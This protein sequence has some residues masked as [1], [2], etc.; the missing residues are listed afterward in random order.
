M[1][2]SLLEPGLLLIAASERLLV[3]YEHKK[4]WENVTSTCWFPLRARND[5]G[6]GWM[7]V[8]LR[9]HLPP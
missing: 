7:S 9:A 3:E 2:F 5:E 6:R 1:G 8:W 4:Q